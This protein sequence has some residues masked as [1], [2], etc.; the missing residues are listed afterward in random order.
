MH[1]PTRQGVSA[2]TPNFLDILTFNLD[3]EDFETRERIEFNAA[4]A[5]K[6]GFV[7]L[8][9]YRLISPEVQENAYW[10]LFYRDRGKG[11]KF[12]DFVVRMEDAPHEIYF[13]FVDDLLLSIG[14]KNAHST[15]LHMLLSNRIKV[16]TQMTFVSKSGIV[17]H[18]SGGLSY[19]FTED[20]LDTAKPERY[21]KPSELPTYILKNKFVDKK[22][23]VRERFFEKEDNCRK[24]TALYDK[25]RKAIKSVSSYE[26]FAIHGT[27]LGLV[28]DGKLIEADDDFDCCYLS[29]YKTPEEVSI[30]RFVIMEALKRAGMKCV[31]SATG[32]IHVRE[33]R[34]MVDIAPAWFDDEGDF[35]TSSYTC[36]PANMDDF[37]PLEPTQYMGQTVMLLKNPELFLERFYG[38]GWGVP[39]PLF[40]TKT[41][42]KAFKR[43]KL[44]VDDAAYVKQLPLRPSIYP[45][46]LAVD[47]AEIEG[48]AQAVVEQPQPALVQVVEPVP[49]P[50]IPHRPIFEPNE[51]A[52]ILA[53]KVRTVMRSMWLKAMGAGI[54]GAAIFEGLTE[55]VA[56]A[57]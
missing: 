25:A 44:F 8:T 42:A 1:M 28:R 38:K 32:H 18:Q 57:Q 2:L 36:F 14:K 39:D 43:R 9:D 53:E 3:A 30:E 35:N 55:I 33:G 27:L 10:H 37:L 4:R 13:T 34:A 56:I 12:E 48:K 31:F 23:F 51:F 47:P 5:A 29:A 49:E 46:V 15:I 22:G 52:D 54:A 19:T 40:S 21:V 7:N 50:E 45:E 17:R 6:M 20:D 11:A 26:T 41:P 16:G 24:T